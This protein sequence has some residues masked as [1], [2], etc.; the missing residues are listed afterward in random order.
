MHTRLK[1]DTLLSF[2]SNKHELTWLQLVTAGDIAMAA[3][4]GC[5]RQHPGDAAAPTPVLSRIFLPCYS[6]LVHL[7]LHC[8]RTGWPYGS[9]APPSALRGSLALVADDACWHVPHNRVAG[10]AGGGG[11]ER[12]RQR[13]RSRRDS[14]GTSLTQKRRRL[15]LPPAAMRIVVVAAKFLSLMGS[16]PSKRTGRCELDSIQQDMQLHGHSGL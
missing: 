15:P 16:V 7:R 12:S 14:L 10:E 13:R 9:P 2:F 8:S 3:P 4:H 11:G 1:L 5:G 6:P